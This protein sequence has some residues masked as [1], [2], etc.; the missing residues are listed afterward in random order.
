MFKFAYV[1]DSFELNQFKF[2]SIL[3]Y[4]YIEDEFYDITLSAKEMWNSVIIL[5]VKHSI[6]QSL[7]YTLGFGVSHN[8]IPHFIFQSSVLYFRSILHTKPE[9]LVSFEK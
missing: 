6:R 2:F 4:L 5:F 7:L 3:F 1:V 9:K 8:G